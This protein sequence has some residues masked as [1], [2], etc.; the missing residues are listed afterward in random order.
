MSVPTFTVQDEFER[1]ETLADILYTIG[2]ENPRHAEN[3]CSP[4]PYMSRLDVS[5]L[6]NSDR[7]VL[8]VFDNEEQIVAGA[9]QFDQ[10]TGRIY[11]LINRYYLAADGSYSAKGNALITAM[12][13]GI[14]DR[15]ESG[16]AVSGS[17][18]PNDHEAALLLGLEFDT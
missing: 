16:R 15:A 3:A 2:V 5:R 9:V 4:V 18:N 17:T 13:E 7:P 6:L 11:N 10:D 8:L 12:V 1:S 14:R